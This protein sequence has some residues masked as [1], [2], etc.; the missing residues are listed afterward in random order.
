ML[1]QFKVKPTHIVPKDY[2]FVVGKVDFI[3]VRFKSKIGVFVH[4]MTPQIFPELEAAL[5]RAQRTGKWFACLVALRGRS[6]IHQSA[7]DV[8]VFL[9]H[10]VLPISL[11]PEKS[12]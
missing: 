5:T 8:G 1:E 11:S 7:R 4:N 3:L 9:R 12:L 6:L 2:F 10:V